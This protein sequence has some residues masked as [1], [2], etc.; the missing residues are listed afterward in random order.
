MC[1]CRKGPKM[2]RGHHLHY[3]QT[4]NNYATVCYYNNTVNNY[5]NVNNNNIYAINN[6]TIYTTIII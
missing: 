3:A 4:Y 5:F 2:S 1:F 6:N